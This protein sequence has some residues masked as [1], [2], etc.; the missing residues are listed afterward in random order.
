[1]EALFAYL[2]YLAVIATASFLTAELILCRA[3]PAAGQLR[4]LARVDV[5]YFT[6]ALAALATGVVRL[7]FYAKGVGFYLPNPFFHAKL[8]LYVLV[9]II[10]ITPTVRFIRWGRA[11]AQGGPPPSPD[12]MRAVRRL[13]HV[14]LMLLALMPLMAVLM[15]RGIGR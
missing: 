14:E 12:D 8:G 15:A 5:S 13:V 11:M 7:F 4:L 10:S 1:M 3:A 6:A 2:H 9:A